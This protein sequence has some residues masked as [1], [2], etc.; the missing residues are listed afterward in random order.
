MVSLFTPVTATPAHYSV[1]ETNSN[2]P[3]VDALVFKVITQPD[4][5]V[6]ALQNDQ[7]DT[8]GDMVN[9]S[10]LNTLMQ[11]QNIEVANLKRNG[12][13]SLV[14]NC[15]KYPLNITAFRRAFAFAPDKYAISDDVWSGLSSPQDS[16]VPAMNPFSIESQLT[17]TYYEA[18][19]ALG[20]QPLQNAGF[21]GVDSDGYREAPEGS[22]FSVTTEC[23]QS[24][25]IAL[26]V[27]QIAANALSAL[28][29]DGGYSPVDFYEYLNQLYFYGD[30]DMVFLGY[31][32]SDLDVDWLTYDYCSEYADVPY[33]NYPSFRNSSYDSWRE[34]LINSTSFEDVREAAIEM[35]R[36]LVYQCLMVLCYE[37]TLFSAYRTDRFDG[38]VD[39]VSRGYRVGE[40]ATGLT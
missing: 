17:Y 3:F 1:S 29:V 18:N 13:G 14:I 30:F 22:D 39:D 32:F 6:L 27:D 23:A 21:L 33:Y 11:N 20:N 7:I 24:L 26:Q 5:Q 25:L 4:Q 36:I 31:S 2:G 38:F 28:G 10:F 37:N 16:V 15:A 19:M 12:Y 34:Q 9:P 35:Q 40:P 8:I